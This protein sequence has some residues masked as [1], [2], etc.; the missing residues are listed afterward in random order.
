MDTFHP[1]YND[2]PLVNVTEI[3]SLVSY[4]SSNSSSS[5]IKSSSKIRKINHLIWGFKNASILSV[6]ILRGIV[7]KN[8]QSKKIDC[9]F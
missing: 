5:V 4:D 8:R 3:Y 6:M 7:C 1:Y 2:F 9:R